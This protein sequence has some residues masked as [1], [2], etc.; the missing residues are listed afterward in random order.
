MNKYYSQHGED[1]LLS[2][3]FDNKKKGFFVEVGCIDGMRFSNTLYFENLG[4]EGICVE[5][6]NDYI[7]LLQD[8]RKKSKIIHTAVGSIDTPSV[9]FYANARG[10]LSTVDINQESF[11]KEKYK[12]Y[13]TGFE[14][15]NV[16]MLTLDKIFEE[17]QV[18][19]ID[20]LSI[21]IEGYE[22][23]ALKGLN[24]EKH[25]PIVIILEADTYDI[26]KEYDKILS[27]YKY[28]PITKIKNNVIFSR[29]KEYRKIIN[30][31]TFKAVEL[32]HTEHPLDSNGNQIIFFDIKTE[33]PIISPFQKKLRQYIRK[34]IK[35]VS[36]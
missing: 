18:D 1:F 3:L 36:Q 15:Q 26:I 16:S 8:N 24:L 22:I 31:K 34:F 25:Q 9:T 20:I 5:A 13:F 19:H 14:E 7:G 6:H 17:N 12:N 32:T 2:L 4:W 10:S 27:Q 11:F 23:E 33:E 35:S 21:D 30:K 29:K 28:F